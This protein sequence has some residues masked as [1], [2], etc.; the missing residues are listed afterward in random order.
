MDLLHLGVRR[1]DVLAIS[2]VP[3]LEYLH[4]VL[5]PRLEVLE[6]VLVLHVVVDLD[7]VALVLERVDHRHT[8]QLVLYSVDYVVRRTRIN[9]VEYH[10]A[11]ELLLVG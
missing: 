4:E 7:Q 5:L 6:G 8:R 11:H 9:L 3:G 1:L 2:L 10:R